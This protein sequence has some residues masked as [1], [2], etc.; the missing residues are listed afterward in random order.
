MMIQRK[1]QDNN[2]EIPV[3]KRKIYQFLIE[4][5]FLHLSLIPNTSVKIETTI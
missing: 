3:H 5:Q 4:V 1:Y 2:H